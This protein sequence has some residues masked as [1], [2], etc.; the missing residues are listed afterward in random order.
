MAPT[1]QLLGQHQLRRLPAHQAPPQRGALQCTNPHAEAE[2]HQGITL[3]RLQ[4]H[5]PQQPIHRGCGSGDVCCQPGLRLLL[6]DGQ[7]LMHL[8]AGAAV[9]DGPGGIAAGG[10]GIGAQAAVLPAFDQ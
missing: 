7:A 4:L 2:A 6:A 10:I 8:R 3:P 1:R 9:A 5:P